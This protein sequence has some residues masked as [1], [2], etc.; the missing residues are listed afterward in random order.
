[1]VS[2][3]RCTEHE[4]LY[5]SSYLYTVKVR[6]YVSMLEMYQVPVPVWLS[7]LCQGFCFLFRTYSNGSSRRGPGSPS[8]MTQSEEEG[9]E[10]EEEVTHLSISSIF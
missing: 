3:F 1:M 8:L 9:S 6:Y 7:F 10:E 5:M 2:Y 4:I